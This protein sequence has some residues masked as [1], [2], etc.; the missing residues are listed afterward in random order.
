MPSSRGS[1][2]PKDWTRVSYVS[3]IGRWVLYHSKQPWSKV[4]WWIAC[5]SPDMPKERTVFLGGFFAHQKDFYSHLWAMDH[6]ENCLF[7]G[8]WRFTLLQWTMLRSHH[9]S[10]SGSLT[11]NMCSVHLISR[12]KWGMYTGNG[13]S[14]ALS[15]RTKAQT[16][17]TPGG[18]SEP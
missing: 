15:L 12:Y 11:V 9:H 17:P 14:G 1:S 6:R 8:L 4:S 10:K 2:W 13:D 18:N 16:L 5:Q 7:I 3:C